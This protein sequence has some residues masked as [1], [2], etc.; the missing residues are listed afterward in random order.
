MAIDHSPFLEEEHEV[1]SELPGFPYLR[2]EPILLLDNNDDV[3]ELW[4]SEQEE[5]L[6]CVHGVKGQL[7]VVSNHRIRVFRIPK[8]QGF[9]RGTAG[10]LFDMSPLG[11]IV[12]AFD[13]VKD[14]AVSA[15]SF[16]KWVSPKQ[17]R[18]RAENEAAGMPNPKDFEDVT[19]KIKDPNI[20][21]MISCYKERVL[22]E[23]AFKW[24]LLHEEYWRNDEKRYLA[25]HFGEK[26]IT[27]S[28]ADSEGDINSDTFEAA[29]PCGIPEIAQFVAEIN[30]Q[31]LENSGWTAVLDEGVLLHDAAAFQSE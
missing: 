5:L 8:P 30:F 17:R 27:F 15:N 31:L 20:L 14:V 9:M 6:F 18:Q 11:E 16:R 22:L 29:E 10:F 3:D 2:I 24:K 25:I 21:A 1:L 23:N 4:R 7:L 13:G 26:Q 19:W 28:A 12:G